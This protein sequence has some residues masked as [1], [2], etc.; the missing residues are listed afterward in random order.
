MLAALPRLSSL[1]GFRTTRWALVECRSWHCRRKA[2]NDS[3]PSVQVL[4]SFTTAPLSEL[5][6]SFARRH[7]QRRMYIL[8][9]SDPS[10]L[11][12][13]CRHVAANYLL[14]VC[15]LSAVRYS[16]PFSPW[17]RRCQLLARIVPSKSPRSA[18]R[19]RGG[20]TR[21]ASQSSDMTDRAETLA[22]LSFRLT[23]PNQSDFATQ[24]WDNRG[25]AW[26]SAGPC[27]FLSRAVSLGL[28]LLVDGWLRSDSV[29][30][31]WVA[32]LCRP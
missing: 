2:K 8:T 28:G 14:P 11:E 24:V 13:D 9:A 23:V 27:G 12:L 26:R 25:C 17:R 15:A 21:R 1:P 4:V 6:I 16:T 7:C 20:V 18:E 19:R 10:V 3:N 29:V 5:C 31:G 32:L 22:R 30:A